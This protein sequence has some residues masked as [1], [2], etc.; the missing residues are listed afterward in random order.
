MPANTACYAGYIEDRNGNCTEQDETDILEVNGDSYKAKNMKSSA[1]N[2]QKIW[3][4]VQKISKK[5]EIKY[6][7]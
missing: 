5:Y 6:N 2:M 1:K 7:D 4:Q 3:N